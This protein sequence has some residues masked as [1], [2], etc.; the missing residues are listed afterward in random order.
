VTDGAV[1]KPKP[2]G[3]IAVTLAVLSFS[4]SSAIIKWAESTGAVIA[5][6]RM[7][8]AII[9]WWV[10]LAVIRQ[11]TRRPWPTRRTWRLVLPAGLFFGLNIA[12]FF[13]AIT[14]TSI[15]HAEFITTLT[16]LALVPAGTLIFGERPNWKAL[17]FGV[18]SLVGVSL[19]LLF[20]PD[21]GDST[22]SG[23][24]L[25]I[26]VVGT[27][28]GYM[29][30]SKRA[31]NSGVEVVDFMACMMPL[32]VIT[33]GPIAVSIAGTGLFALSARAWVAVVILTI[34]T[35]MV[36]HG[37]IIFAQHHLPVATIGIMQTG[38]PALAVMWGF[39]ILGE[40][41]RAAQVVGMVLVVAGLSLFTR[42]SQRHP[43]VTSP[44]RAD[45]GANAATADPPSR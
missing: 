30:T 13:T 27:W 36:A 37:L 31:R 7:I 8:G 1:L 15:A 10:V 11:R 17:R 18:I 20:G 6:W 25:M 4:I 3:F 41:V 19:V 24:L 28:T 5:F 34:F 40:S 29:L 39:I 14:R 45:L 26:V 12:L 38:Q 43:V 2:V 33:A 32:G 23:D 42:A 44:A 9:G 22:L 35:G 16:P 21:G